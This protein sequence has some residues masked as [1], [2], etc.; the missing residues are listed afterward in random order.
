MQLSDSI[1][2]WSIYLVSTVRDHILWLRECWKIFTLNADLE[3]GVTVSV[4]SAVKIIR[5][6]NWSSVV[7]MCFIMPPTSKKLRGHIGL[8]LSVCPSD[9]LS[10]CP[11]VRL[12]VTP[13]VG[14]KTREPLELGTW[15][16][17]CS[18]STKNKRTRIFFFFRSALV[19]QSYA[20][21]STQS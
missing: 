5:S 15:N 20:P 17:I 4:A 12:S 14:C 13:Y 8:G 10:V 18:I 16:F 9:R 21:F 19:W 6:S 2:E 11:S 1:I 3:I 7:K